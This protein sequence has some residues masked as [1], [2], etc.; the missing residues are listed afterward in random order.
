MQPPH[1]SA[2]DVVGLAAARAAVRLWPPKACAL[3]SAIRTNGALAIICRE[4]KTVGLRDIQSFWDDAVELLG[5]GDLVVFLRE[6]VMLSGTVAGR[7]VKIWGH[8]LDKIGHRGALTEQQK[9]GYNLEQK[10]KGLKSGDWIVDFGGNLGI[11]AIHLKFR[12]PGC[13]VLT[14]EPSPW[15]YILLR[16]NLL[17]NLDGWEGIGALRGGLAGVTG[18][19]SGSHFFGNAWAS[20]REDIFN[21]SYI[22]AAPSE[23]AKRSSAKVGSFVAP[24][25]T[26]AGVM[27][28]FGIDKFALLKLDCEGCEWDVVS[29]AL[30]DGTWKKVRSSFGEL[31]AL[32]EYAEMNIVKCLPRNMS[33]KQASKVW[34]L[35]CG[36]SKF[37]FE[38]GC[39]DPKFGSL[40]TEVADVL[41]QRVCSSRGPKKDWQEK[42]YELLCAT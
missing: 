6:C 13:R 38:W 21:G 7:S 37:K 40:S 31:H 41:R 26:M 2:V 4:S 11:T 14:V 29:Q 34:M 10:C 39:E 8:S 32:C 23:W 9:D 22:K 3:A 18:S 5:E 12:C 24:L 42:S 16:L 28:E 19:M 1:K 27:D 33:I 36:S 17:Q 20:R 30:K 35:L 15:N 25:L